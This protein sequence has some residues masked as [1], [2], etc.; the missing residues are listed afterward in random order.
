MPLLKREKLQEGRVFARLKNKK[1]E[2]GLIVFSAYFLRIIR[3]ASTAP[4]MI[5][6]TMMAIMPGSIHWSAVV[7]GAVVP[8]GPGVALAVDKEKAVSA[9]DP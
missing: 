4:T 1:R 6:T 3:I 2:K 9:D 7:P 5:T 8:D